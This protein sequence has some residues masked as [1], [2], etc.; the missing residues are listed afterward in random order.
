M[1][2]NITNTGGGVSSSSIAFTQSHTVN[3]ASLIENERFSFS[4]L[5]LE[6]SSKINIYSSLIVIVIGLTGNFL[7]IFVFGQSRFRTNPSSVYLLC[8]AVNDSLFLVI[9]F[10]EGKHKI[11]NHLFT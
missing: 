1:I 9:H 2:N 4:N 6:Y 5:V 8:L 10:F 7:T 3:D 11:K